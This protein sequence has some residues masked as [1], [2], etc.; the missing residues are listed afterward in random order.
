MDDLKTIKANK[1]KECLRR[2]REL[3]T[4]F[5]MELS[6]EYTKEWFEQFQDK[7]DKR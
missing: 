7:T 3:E 1:Q 2:K 5:R 4:L 6:K